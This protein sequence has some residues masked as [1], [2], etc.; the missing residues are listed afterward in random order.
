MHVLPVDLQ[1]AGFMQNLRK[2]MRETLRRIHRELLQKLVAHIE[3]R[4]IA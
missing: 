4:E 3:R 1:A 2:E